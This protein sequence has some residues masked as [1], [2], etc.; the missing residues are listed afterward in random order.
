MS[1]NRTLLTLGGAA[2]ALALGTAAASAATAFASSTVNVRSGPGTGYG[3]VDALYPGERVD[4]DHCRGAWCFVEKRGPD[5]WVNANYLTQDRDR[6][7][8]RYDD[9][10]DP[11]PFYVVRPHFRPFYPPFHHYPIPRSQVCIGGSNAS[12]CITD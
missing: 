4:V 8:D 7:D 12:F 9:D 3:I 6:W 11:F 2:L 10:E 1:L 5:G